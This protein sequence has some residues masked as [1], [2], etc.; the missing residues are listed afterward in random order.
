[1]S[2]VSLYAAEHGG[3]TKKGFEIFVSK[4]RKPR[5]DSGL[6]CLNSAEFA[7]AA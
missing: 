7:H 4:W 5:V 3:T 2:E 1:M 6:D